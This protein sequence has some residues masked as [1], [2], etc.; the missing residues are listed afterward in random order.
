MWSAARQATPRDFIQPLDARGGFGEAIVRRRSMIGDF[1]H[2]FLVN[3]KHP[4]LC[5]EEP[6]S[7]MD[8]PSGHSQSDPTGI[9]SNSAS[10]F[11][12][13]AWCIGLTM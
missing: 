3:S 8:S 4:S 10:T 11:M 13:A 6:N 2:L 5:V 7:M 9:G 12:R 1:S